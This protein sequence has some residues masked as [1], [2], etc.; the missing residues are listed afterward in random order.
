MTTD[1]VMNPE[2]KSIYF[3]SQSSQPLDLGQTSPQKTPSTFPSSTVPS[4][5]IVFDKGDRRETGLQ[6][7]QEQ[8]ADGAHTGSAKLV[9]NNRHFVNEPL[10]GPPGT[11]SREPAASFRKPDISSQSVN[12]TPK[13]QNALKHPRPEDNK[14]TGR[15][16]GSAEWP[17]KK[18]PKLRPRHTLDPETFSSALAA[19]PRSNQGLPPSPLFFSHTQRQRPI[20]PPSFS[21]SD[22][23]ATM[24]NKARDEAGGVTTLKLAR[25]SRSNASPPLSTTTPGSWASL[26]RNSVSSSP[27][28]RGKPSTGLQILGNVGIVELLEQDERPIFVIDV[29]NPVNLSP[30]GTLQIV[31]ANASFRAYPTLLEMVTGRVDLDSLGI[32]VANDFP[33]FKAWALSFVKNNESLDICLPSFLYEGVTWTCLTLRKRLRLIS[34][35]GF[36]AAAGSPSSNGAPSISSV[37]SERPRGPTLN[38]VGPSPLI[39]STEPLDYFGDAAI[40]IRSTTSTS[41]QQLMSSPGT[42]SALSP[43]RQAMIVSQSDT[44][45]SEMMSTRYPEGSSFDWTRL[46]MSAALPRHIQFA[47]SID[48]ASTPLGPIKSWTFDLRAMC[49]LVM[50]SPHPAAM[51]WGTT[52]IFLSFT[53]F[54]VGYE[55]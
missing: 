17:P 35:S 52:R 2:I 54:F 33:E 14:G 26:E 3:S 42:W 16:G 37:L 48:W 5:P 8:R 22:A 40:Q 24:L 38:S 21:S 15:E 53:A 25:G 47:R 55:I 51:Y 49:N 44:L 12:S 31:F 43:S 27:D 41:P 7:K 19:N 10:Q 13:S 39:E 9:E 1:T 11:S 34:G 6:T 29:A 46:P 32:A 50:G 20:L 23:A 30:G 18:R 36:P 4:S 45:T 28:S